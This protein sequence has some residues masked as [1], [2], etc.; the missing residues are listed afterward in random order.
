LF[1]DSSR[2]SRTLQRRLARTPDRLREGTRDESGFGLIELLVVILIIG[3]L[4]AIALPS[5]LSQKSKAYDAAAKEL[6]HSAAVTAETIATD[7]SGEYT[8][9]TAA[10]LNK[11][12]PAIQ[13]TA[14][15][16]NAYISTV[17]PGKETYTL[18]AKAATTGDE[19]T[20]KREANGS[21]IRTCTSAKGSKNCSGSET[22]SW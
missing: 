9:V 16:G 2:T 7:N 21:V 6:V 17:T 1:T 4:A 20:I 10:E 13:T 15:G 3:V 11:Y 12:E 18:T 8:K 22:G 14:G 19:F 5:L